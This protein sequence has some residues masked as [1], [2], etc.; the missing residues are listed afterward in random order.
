MRIKSLRKGMIYE[1]ESFS[2]AS[3]DCFLCKR[4]SE[5]IGVVG[6]SVRRFV[7]FARKG[8]GCVKCSTNWETALSKFALGGG[9][10]VAN[11]LLFFL[12]RSL[13]GKPRTFASGPWPPSTKFYLL[14]YHLKIFHFK[15]GTECEC[16]QCAWT[17]GFKTGTSFS[18]QDY[19]VIIPI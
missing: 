14:F 7:Y 3:N 17:S 5:S 6:Q 4:R 12:V 1:G 19:R 11:L 9:V 8:S 2:A 13:G 18:K 10:A 16:A 15:L